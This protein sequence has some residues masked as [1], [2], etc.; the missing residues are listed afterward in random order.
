MQ[1]G[2]VKSLIKATQ[3]LEYLANEVSEQS[4]VEVARGV[5][6]HVAT[7]RRLLIT[8]NHTDFIRKNE[9]TK[10]YSLGLKIMMLAE[11]V[12]DSLN[13]RE[14]SIPFLRELM[15]KSGETANLVIEDKDAVVYIEQVESRN[16]LRTANKVG[17]RAPMYCTA[18]GKILLAFRPVEDIESYIRN[19]S[20]TR[21]THKTIIDKEKLKEELQKIY[22]TNIAIDNEEQ[23]KGE[24]CVAAPI[25]D[26]TGKVIAAVSISGPS[27]RIT[28]KRIKELM[29]LTVEIGMKISKQFGF[30]DNF[31]QT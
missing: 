18:C 20:F 23:M 11:K 12:T 5:G 17:S 19:I 15:E 10:K 29:T 13:L 7:A 28:P 24:C 25:R 26:H 2:T 3:I 14:V 9:Q 16:Y 21:F 4:L 31:Y 27:F 22:R 30:I 1:D 8:L 6:L